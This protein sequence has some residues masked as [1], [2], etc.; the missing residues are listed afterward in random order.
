[1]SN[2]IQFKK[3]R[4][5]WRLFALGGSLVLLAAL[6]VN[7]FLYLP[8]GSGPTEPSVESAPFER[9]WTERQILLVGIGDSVTAGFGASKG[10]SYFDRLITNPPDEFADMRVKCLSRVLPNLKTLNIAVSGSNS[11]QHLDH[12]RD[13]LPQQDQGIFGLVVI[14]TGGNDLIHW[15]GNRRHARVRCMARHSLKPRPG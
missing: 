8:M 2:V 13:R 1:V 11:L 7:F 6:Y 3:N 14:T 12:I 4:R 5:M 10:K 15:Y 9:P